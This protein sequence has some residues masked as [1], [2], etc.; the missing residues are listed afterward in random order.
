M[1]IWDAKEEK[2][3]VSEVLEGARH[4]FLMSLALCDPTICNNQHQLNVTLALVSKF[5]S[6]LE[7]LD[8]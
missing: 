7:I 5:H 1:A 3:D 8:Y 4:K 2:G 6:F